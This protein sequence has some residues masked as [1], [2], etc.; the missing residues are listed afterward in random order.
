MSSYRN[1]ILILS[2]AR[3]TFF[4]FFCFSLRKMVDSEYSTDNYK[5]L[6]ISTRILIKNPEMLRFI[7]D[8]FRA[9]LN[10]QTCN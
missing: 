4:T 3:T 8:H 2:L 6:K 9:K 5:S 1:I 7:P 10:V